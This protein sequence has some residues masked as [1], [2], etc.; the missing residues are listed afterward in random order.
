MYYWLAGFALGCLGQWNDLWIFWIN[1]WSILIFLV[2]GLLIPG[3]RFRFFF[4]A[5]GLFWASV[6]TGYEPRDGLLGKVSFRSFGFGDGFLIVESNN[7]KYIV[8]G[9]AYVGQLGSVQCNWKKFQLVSKCRLVGTKPKPDHILLVNM[10]L[11]IKSR[12]IELVD[13]LPWPF[14]IWIPLTI[15][16]WRTGA[17]ELIQAFY[18]TGLIHLLVV[19]GLH[20]AMMSR[21]LESCFTWPNRLLYVFAS[22]KADRWIRQD[23]SLVVMVSSILFFYCYFVGFDPPCQRAF[24]FYIFRNLWKEFDF[25][26][27]QSVLMTLT[28]QSLLFPLSFFSISNI[29]TWIAWIAISWI[30]LAQRSNE[31]KDWFWGWFVGQLM[32]MGIVF[33]LTQKI[34]LLG[35]MVSSLLGVVFPLLW[36]IGLFVLLMGITGVELVELELLKLP[37]IIFLECLYALAEWNDIYL[38][39]MLAIES[40]WSKALILFLVGTVFLTIMEHFFGKFKYGSTMARKNSFDHRRLRSHD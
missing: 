39:G 2:V 20:I 29:L 12:L 24:F 14:N 15:F 27:S 10:S 7:K 32:I 6:Y 22:I 17:S 19:S 30:R 26:K 28:M 5:A 33:V 40:F 9:D 31:P 18:N 8:K 3:Y 35:L 1:F 13:E 23:R 21:F 36:S 34:S 11:R 25:R 4:F 16:G 38:G 37:L